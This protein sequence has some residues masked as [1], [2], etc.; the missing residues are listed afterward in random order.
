[1]NMS[2]PYFRFGLFGLRRSGK[3]VFLAAL[4]AERRPISDESTIAYIDTNPPFL[5]DQTEE[6]RHRRRDQA[7]GTYLEN[8]QFLGQGRV[9][10]ATE[11]AEGV[12]SHIFALTAGS[13]PP[14]G[15]SRTITVELLDYAGELLKTES[16]EKELRKL[17]LDVLAE[18]DGLIILAEAPVKAAAETETYSVQKLTDL[19]TALQQLRRLDSGRDLHASA[20]LVTKWDRIRP[21]DVT[22]HDDESES[23]FRQRER[24]EEE[25]HRADFGQWLA[26]VPEAR[27]IREL[28]RMLRGTFPQDDYSVWPNSAFGISRL[29]PDAEGSNIEICARNELSSLNLVEPL[30]FLVDRAR[31]HRREHLERLAPGDGTPSAMVPSDSEIRAEHGDDPA[32]LAHVSSVRS[33]AEAAERAA[34]EREIA[35]R[36]KLRQRFAGLAFGGLAIA[37]AIGA[38][39]VYWAEAAHVVA[40]RDDALS[41]VSSDD[42]A[43]VVAVH[44]RVLAEEDRRPVLG[45][46]LEADEREQIRSSLAQR[47]CLLWGRKVDQETTDTALARVRQAVLPQCA[48]LDAA[49][50][51]EEHRRWQSAL[52]QAQDALARV[53]TVENCGNPAFDATV[54]EEAYQSVLIALGAAPAGV[55]PE[56]SA[57]VQKQVSQQRMLCLGRQEDAALQSEHVRAES[58][59]LEQ[60]KWLEFF[61]AQRNFLGQSDGADRAKRLKLV[62]RSLEAMERAMKEWIEQENPSAPDQERKLV[63]DLIG[64]VDALKG[65]YSADLGKQLDSLRATATD[66]SSRLDGLALCKSVNSVLDSYALMQNDL[67]ARDPVSMKNLSDNVAKL[68]QWGSATAPMIIE[69]T[70]VIDRQ[71]AEIDVIDTTV[72]GNFLLED[73]ASQEVRALVMIGTSKLSIDW[74]N[75]VTKENGF[76]LQSSDVQRLG[77]EGIELRLALEQ[78]RRLGRNYFGGRAS[79]GRQDLFRNLTD[80]S[81]LTSKLQMAVPIVKDENAGDLAGVN[82]QPQ[83]GHVV[84]VR[85]T[86]RAKRLPDLKEAPACPRD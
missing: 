29:A 54:L 6:E 8:T 23:D 67:R 65:R 22:R 74:N 62:E 13:E 59:F 72:S 48:A 45:P 43:R 20:L 60:R 37:C 9:P 7:K 50:L 34:T 2:N 44:D 15:A 82:T 84:R 81:G 57:E 26:D 4:N 38:F 10:A 5:P 3:S 66:I 11:T 41:A 83:S 14:S 71:A 16:D 19:A 52:L 58:V 1:M 28:D 69:I 73:R 70:A 27:R 30:L 53:A 64:E 85:F 18:T 21:F 80:S 42:L 31:A 12:T 61:A 78:D 25:S 56:T 75:Q 51:Q 33:V 55:M 76:E 49:L 17:L 63:Q 77:K 40:L 79:V 35:Q 68:R 46:A 24:H 32:L 39:G 36:K 47:E 86:L